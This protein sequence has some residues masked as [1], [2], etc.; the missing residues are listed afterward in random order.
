M[1]EISN[2]NKT[3]SSIF[4]EPRKEVQITN[5]LELNKFEEIKL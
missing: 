3:T 2:I 1:K 4:S 5:L